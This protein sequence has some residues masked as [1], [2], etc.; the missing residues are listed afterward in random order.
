LK[1]SIDPDT[2]ELIAVATL[3]WAANGQFYAT[4]FFKKP[5]PTGGCPP[6]GVYAFWK[7]DYTNNIDLQKN[8]ATV[9]VS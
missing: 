2:G 3:R 9:T 4:A 1:C 8:S 6:N 7:Y 5:N